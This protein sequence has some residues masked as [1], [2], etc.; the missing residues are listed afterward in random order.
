MTH[1][2]ARRSVHAVIWSYA[3]GVGKIAAQLIIQILLARMLGPEIFGQYATV[4]VVIGFGWLFADSGFG[5]AL[6]QKKEVSTKD[7]SY[8][9]GWVLL[10]S[11]CSAVAIAVIAPFIAS[12]MGD[13]ALAAPITA[14]GPIVVLQALSNISL[15]LMRRD[16][17]MKRTQLIQL[18]AY[19]L[20][21]GVVAMTLAMLG[22]GVWSLV[23]GFL[24]QTL[25]TLLSGYF[26]VRHTLV[27][28]LHGDAQMRRFGVSVL[29]TNLANWAIENLDRVLVGRQWG[30]A[31]LGSYSAASNLSRVPVSLLVSSFQSVILSSASRVQDDVDRLRRGFIAVLSLVS[32]VTFPLAALLA[33]KADFV[34][35]TLYGNKWDAAGPLFAAFCVALPAYVLLAVAGPTLQA[36]GAAASEF[37]AQVFTAT[38]LFAGLVLLANQPLAL[39]IWFIPCIYLMR[40]LLVYTILAKK[41]FLEHRP[42]IMAVAGGTTL[43]LTIVSMEKIIGYVMQSRA[44]AAPW[45][46]IAQVLAE[47][48]CCF[49]LLRA[50]PHFFVGAELSRMLLARSG[51]SKSARLMCKVIRLRGISK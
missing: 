9:L 2:L 28:S 34:I 27:P 13:L 25:I 44:P 49:L 33:S 46:V 18:A 23:I 10:L 30:I 45:L 31:S 42:A 39:A 12:G 3:G 24:V 37:K 16:L 19:V 17:D 40:F 22:T 6:I 20:G 15:S 32:V 29:G 35:F 50:A 48:M 36:V 11:L 7:I 8:A 43:A 51:E 1:D 26:F 4:L 5:S 21:F 47:G 14:C 41:I 38:V